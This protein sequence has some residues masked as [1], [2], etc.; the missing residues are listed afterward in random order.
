MNVPGIGEVLVIVVNV[1]F[2]HLDINIFK[3]KIDDLWWYL[4]YNY[5]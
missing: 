4:V 5:G 1:R 2:H 3:T